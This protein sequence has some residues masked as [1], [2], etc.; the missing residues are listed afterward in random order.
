VD[1]RDEYGNWQGQDPFLQGED[2]AAPRQ[3]SRYSSLAD[4]NERRRPGSGPI[5]GPPMSG[6]PMSGPPMNAPPQRGPRSGEPLPPLPQHH[7]LHQQPQDYRPDPVEA[8]REP[9]SMVD[10]ASVRRAIADSDGLY[11]SRRPVF[12]ILFGLIGVL[13]T[14]LM[15]RPFLA[16]AFQPSA[17][18]ALAPL[19]G[20]VAF[21]L[22]AI[23]LYGLFTGA[24]S[25]VHF[26]GPRAWL[27][28]PLVYLPIALVLLVA[29]GTAA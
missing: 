24:A 2:Y 22:L 3:E 14:L 8:L 5:S 21:P 6:P 26:Q 16:G 12:M 1:R 13:G 15:V 25:A 19:L 18:G 29:A 20:M 23:G 9:T 11:R 27:K 28:A 17:A 7:S 10:S 4:L